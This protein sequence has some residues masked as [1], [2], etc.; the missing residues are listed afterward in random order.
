M[1]VALSAF[2]ALVTAIESPR[3]R[4]QPIHVL[5]KVEEMYS[6]PTPLQF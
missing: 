5:P 4:K 1:M 2:V 3:K 6:N